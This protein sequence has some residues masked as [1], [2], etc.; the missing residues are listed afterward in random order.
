MN[1]FISWSGERSKHVAVILR[2][3]L[4]KILQAANPWMSEKDIGLGG[5]WS[6]EIAIALESSKFGIICVTAENQNS[7]WVNFECGA[8]SKQLTDAYLVPFLIDMEP[9]DVVGP[10]S[11]F[12]GI[13]VDIEGFRKIVTR[14]N[15]IL[16]A[17]KLPETDITDILDV[18]S[19]RFEEMMS[20]LPVKVDQGVVRTERDILNEV[21]D[22]TREQLRRENERL[23]L[24]RV[25]REK[26][27]E[28]LMTNMDKV[29]EAASFL[30]NAPISLKTDFLGVE[31]SRLSI[32]GIRDLL[33]ESSL[34][35]KKFVVDIAEEARARE[36]NILGK[37]KEV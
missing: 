27:F 35:A 32:E 10:L 29:T 36:A 24:N 7:T 20:K 28:K 3:L 5:R 18:W 15:D 14:I 13:R 23:N 22:N 19:S 34:E 25:S 6:Q 16:G 26:D 11:Q 1:I 30:K 8:I 31:N 17:G 9:S 2:T 37:D 21:L 33:A 12:Q 4:P